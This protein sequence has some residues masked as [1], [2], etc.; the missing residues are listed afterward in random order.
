VDEKKTILFHGGQ[1]PAAP[2]PK[3]PTP[4]P[5]VNH[6]PPPAIAQPPQ[7]RPM[8]QAG[9]PPMGQAGPPPMGQAGPPPMGQAGPQ[10]MGQPGPQF[11]PQPQAQ[12]QQ[13]RPQ[14]WQQPNMGMGMGGGGFS[15]QAFTGAGAKKKVYLAVAGAVALAVL[16]VVGTIVKNKVFGPKTARGSISYASLSLDKKNAH[17]D[18]IIGSLESRARSTWRRDASWWSLGVYGVRPDGTVDLTN[19]GGGVSV[20]FVSASRVQAASKRGRNDSI[21]E[22][23]L[24]PSGVKSDKIISATKAWKGFEP[25]PTP[26]CKIADLVAALGKAGFTDGTVRISFDPKFGFASG[27]NWRVFAKGKPYEGYYSM[28]SCAFSKTAPK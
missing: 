7:P 3:T 23:K 19:A 9:P 12:P 27:W 5:V 25:L 16:A 17:V 28:D 15:P 11:Q 21:K 18:Q 8:G 10:P 26:G 4:Q 13:P 20:K 14:Q 6:G 24:T 2:V 22:Y 1:T